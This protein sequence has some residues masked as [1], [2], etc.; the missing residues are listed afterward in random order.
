MSGDTPR[1]E[2]AISKLI[3]LD[4]ASIVE[5]VHA[6]FARQLERELAAVTAERD[7]LRAVDAGHLSR[8]DGLKTRVEGLA[9]E[10]ERL[11]SA[12]SLIASPMRTDGTWN[13]DREACM[14]LAESALKEKGD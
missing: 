9:A 10:N 2:N 14:E 3:D 8:I 7:A 12:L 13:R 1:T 6:T 11:R 4:G 5:Y